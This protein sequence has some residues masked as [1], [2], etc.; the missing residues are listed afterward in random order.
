MKIKVCGMT[1]PD[2]IVELAALRPDYAGFIFCKSSPRYAGALDPDALK[3]LSPATVPVGVFVDSP[4]DE[5]VGIAGR[6]SIR[7]LQLHGSETPE[8]CSRLRAEGFTVWKAIP[9][10]SASDFRKAEDYARCA[11]ALLFDT[12]TEKAGGSGAKFDWRLLDAYSCNTPFMLSGG[13][14]ADDACA[15]R[16]A[17]LNHPA[18]A[19][20]D[21]NSR[22]ENA[23]GIKNILKIKF[24]LE[25]IL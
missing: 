15:V 11:D 2:N 24:F 4:L 21:I 14:S 20:I 5:V 16:Q 9:V 12:R 3:A 23:P 1:R 13:I 18:M 19:G 22:F 10:A 17:F 7:H 6:Y 8:Y 25:S